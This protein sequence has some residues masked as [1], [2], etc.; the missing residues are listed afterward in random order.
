[1]VYLHMYVSHCRG[2][3]GLYMSMSPRAIV[4]PPAIAGSSPG[5]GARSCPDPSV[6]LKWV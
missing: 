1:M 5:H 6:E 2:G 4:C 3:R